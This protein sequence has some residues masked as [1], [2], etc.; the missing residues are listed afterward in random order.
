MPLGGNDF[1]E[2]GE[3][4]A[5]EAHAQMY[6]DTGASPRERGAET[7]GQTSWF[8]H[9]PEVEAGRAEP[10][11][12]SPQQKATILPDV[13]HD[14][15][16]TAGRDGGQ[17]RS[18]RHQS[19]EQVNPT[20]RVSLR[21][22]CRNHVSRLTDAPTPAKDFQ[23][24]YDANKALFDKY[25]ELRVG[26]DNKS[27]VPGGHEIN[28]GGVGPGAVEVACKLDQKSAF[29]I[30]KGEIIPTG[31][32][33]LKTKFKNYPIEDR[34]ADLK[35]PPPTTPSTSGT[36]EFKDMVPQGPLGNRISSRFPTAVR[37]T[38]NPMNHDLTLS[39]SMILQQP[40]IAERLAD[41]VVA[42]NKSMV[43]TPEDLK[44]PKGIFDAFERQAMDNI[45]AVYYHALPA[46]RITNRV[47][48]D[49]AHE[50]RRERRSSKWFGAEAK[51][52]G[53]R[54]AVSPKRLESERLI[55]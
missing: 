17:G 27:A 42:Q 6:S 1:S 33:G 2:N 4:S 11:R 29:D 54:Y 40:K 14:W 16:E 12:N 37:A 9:N 30:A 51:L 47:W 45:K 18:G 28:I 50:Y 55:I 53:Y 43:F 41:K 22:F 36:G 10:R 52:G 35:T 24:F 26:W 38:E 7:E 8:F 31:G 3:K 23:A 21:K 13:S 46:N 48:Y 5:T 20:R 19:A 44:T 39:S 32:T 25:P 49:G 34:I 15:H